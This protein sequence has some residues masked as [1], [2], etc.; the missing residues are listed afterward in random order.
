MF[1]VGWFMFGA[2]CNGTDVGARQA[3]PLRVSR[4]WNVMNTGDGSSFTTCSRV[5]IGWSFL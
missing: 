2:G 1:A 5:S 4:Y 3:A